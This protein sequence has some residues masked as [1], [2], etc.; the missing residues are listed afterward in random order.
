MCL[1]SLPYFSPCFTHTKEAQ[2]GGIA[3][4]C[5][6]RLSLWYSLLLCLCHRAQLVKGR[7][8]ASRGHGSGELSTGRLVLKEPKTHT[9]HPPLPQNTHGRSYVGWQ[10]NPASTFWGLGSCFGAPLQNVVC[11]LCVGSSSSR[12]R[13]ENFL[14]FSVSPDFGIWSSHQKWGIFY[15]YYLLL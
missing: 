15:S 8:L 9:R 3:F 2:I 1:W 4:A 5:S 12:Q 6:F 14:N 10:R 11:K 13:S 7:Q